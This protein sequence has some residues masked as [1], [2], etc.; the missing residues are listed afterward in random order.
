MPSVANDTIPS[1]TSPAPPKVPALDNTFGA[2]QL[3]TFVGLIVY[4]ITLHQYYR[5]IRSYPGDSRVLK[6]L[7]FVVVDMD[8]SVEH[9]YMVRI[10]TYRF[11]IQ[12]RA[13]V[14]TS[15]YYLTTNYFHPEVLEN[16]V[17]SLNLLPVSSA[18]VMLAAQSFFARRVWI[19]GRGFRPLVIV[20]S[21]LCVAEF[22]ASTEA[23]TQYSFAKFSHYTWL[24]STGFTLAMAADWVLMFVLIY[25][26]HSNRTGFQSTDS[27]IDLMILYTVNTGV[28]TG[29]VDLLSVIFAFYAPRHLIYIALGIVGKKLYATTLLAALNSRNSLK[30]HGHQ[31]SPYGNSISREPVSTRNGHRFESTHVSSS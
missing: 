31:K 17:W 25:I 20:V 21:M 27:M 16:G 2:I 8:N 22:A 9:A 18:V 26:L 30:T 10:H 29:I 6:C 19:L 28:L 14:S 5:Y 24:V 3:G 7:V 12:T 1:A 4:G 23:F 13:H 15:Y 11:E